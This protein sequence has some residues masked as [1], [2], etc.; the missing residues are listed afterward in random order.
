MSPQYAPPPVTL[1]FDLFDIESS[2]RVAR[3]VRYLCANFNFNFSRPLHSRLKP[4]VSD[5]Q[6]DSCQTASS[7]NANI[8]STVSELQLIL[9][10]KTTWMDDLRNRIN[11]TF[12]EGQLHI[13]CWLKSSDFYFSSVVFAMFSCHWIA[14]FSRRECITKPPFS[15]VN[16]HESSWSLVMETRPNSEDQDH[17]K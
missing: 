1:T 12:T 3:N 6:I 16:G 9:W 14:F 13:K 10:L 17:R 15:F 5:R 8:I 7:L 11:H 2:V 4:D